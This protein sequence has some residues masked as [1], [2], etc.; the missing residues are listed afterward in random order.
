[1]RYLALF[2]ICLIFCFKVFAQQP[3][4]TIKGQVFDKQSKSP[5]IGAN[6]VVLDDSVFKG[7]ATDMNGYYRIVKV[8]VGRKR[9]KI[10]YLGYKEAVMPIVVNSGKETVTNIELE[11]SVVESKEVTVSAKIRKDRSNNEMAT[12][13]SRAFTIDE[14]QRY[15]GSRNDPSRMAANYAG[16]SGA[17]DDR[18]D[19]I[20]RGNSPT[21][22]LWRLNGIDIP[23]PNHFGSLG[24]T[25]GPVSI[26]NNNIL[27]NSDFMT[28][29]FSAEYGNALAGVFDLKMRSG[30]NEKNEFLG[31]VGL[32]GFELGAEGPFYKN[33]KASYLI[34]YRYSTLGLFH[35]VGIDFGAGTAVPQYQDLSF[36]VDIP[37]LKYGK[38][39]IFGIG[40]KSHVDLLDSQ[41]DT[42]KKDLYNKYNSD[43]YF[44]SNTGVVGISHT[45]FF[46]NTTYAK[47]SL[48]A[49]G[50]S[51]TTTSYDISP[52]G[53]ATN[54]LNYGQQVYQINYTA[55]YI[56][57]KKFNAKNSVNIGFTANRIKM[58]FED[59]VKK[60]SAVVFQK[61]RDFKGSAYL[62]QAYI[63]WQH[64][65]TDKLTLNAGLHYQQFTLNNSTAIEPRIGIRK[66]LNNNQW[67][68]LAVG[69][70]SQM[71]PMNIYFSGTVLPNG[72]YELTNR[73]LGFTRSNHIVLAYDKTLNDVMRL[74]VE[75]YFQYI[76]N[77]PVEQ[78]SSYYSLLNYGANFDN[79]NI[80]SLVNKGTGKNYGIEFTLE[81]FYNKGYYFLFTGS[82]FNSTYRGSNGVQYN[83]VFNGNYV[84]NA[85]AGKEFKLSSKNVFAA[86]LKLTYA[87]GK[88]YI[89]VNL[90]ASKVANI[91]VDD[92]ANAYKN[93][94]KDYFRTDIKVTFR[95]N[96]RRITQEFLIDFQNVFN[97]QNVF[98]QSYNAKSQTI[99]TEYQIGLFIIPQYRI[100][101]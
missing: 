31:Q 5:L 30:N 56:V 24:T 20:I 49:S 53:Q 80:D 19:I 6:V 90:A 35:K 12:V 66:E 86:D 54:I 41:K 43:I 8:G 16:V 27:D 76:T 73:S 22:L 79:P 91:E 63:Q 98:L 45:Y 13:S 18:N 55:S 74:K 58:H 87:G 36:K 3:S 75:T 81:R 15:A 44:G 17:S 10:T 51:N 59:S 71:Q 97:I 42:T 85:L 34:N 83:A 7:T 28:G 96:G 95:R 4:Q 29:A 67:I 78:R 40:G 60:D 70:H 26:L 37:S 68:S 101:F 9:I 33:S 2:F 39:S 62:L 93:K 57:N 100:L 92:V 89:P 50:S 1:M 94:L 64:K 88:R 77:A 21:G 69:M 65:F 82:V 61:L 99:N 14:T 84:F 46:N 25:G 72:Q 48:S 32:N 47:L 38:I 11:E 52:A 23:N